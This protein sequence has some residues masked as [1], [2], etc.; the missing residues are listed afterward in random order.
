MN[1]SLKVIFSVDVEPDCMSFFKESYRGI[2]EGMEPL[3]DLLHEEGVKATF[4]TTGNVAE[5]FPDM[6]RKVVTLG[7]ELG[8]H[9][10]THTPFTEMDR[11]TAK[12]EIRTAAKILRKFAPVTSFRAPY[13]KFPDNY[14]DLL[15]D[16]GFLLDSSQ[17]KYK[18]AYYRKTSPTKL[19]RA[20]VSVTSSFLRLPLWFRTPIFNILTSPVVLYAHPWEFV[21]MRNEKMRLDC[22]F[23]TGQTALN[24]L[25]SALRF[26]KQR[27]ASFC[28]ISE[29]YH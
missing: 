1:K 7:H 16:E 12:E 22:R 21:D 10:L 15:E 23:K 13:L 2:E 28:K 19:K 3:L 26:F 11:E 5:K 18:L 6:T 29:L 17:A 24:C 9:G 20:P 14:L 27:N 25:R 8:C 4:F